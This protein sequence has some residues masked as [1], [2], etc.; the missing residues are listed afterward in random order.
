[1]GDNKRKRNYF[2][3]FIFKFKYS[4]T[5]F[6]IKSINQPCIHVQTVL[7]PA[8]LIRKKRVDVEGACTCSRALGGEMN[9]QR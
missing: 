5:C 4:K 7:F 8:G 3:I 1:M 6:P 9:E 2:T